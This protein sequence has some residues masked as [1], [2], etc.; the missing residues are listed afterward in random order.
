MI[1]GKMCLTRRCRIVRIANIML[2]TLTS[3]M[4]QN[5]D[6]NTRYNAIILDSNLQY[7]TTGIHGG[8]SENARS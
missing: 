5:I 2:P 4:A 3:S 6:L 8:T 1:H 7:S